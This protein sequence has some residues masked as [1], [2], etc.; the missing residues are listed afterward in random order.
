VDAATELRDRG[1]Y[2]FTTRAQIGSAAAKQA[3]NDAAGR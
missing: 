1:T 3:F 2:G